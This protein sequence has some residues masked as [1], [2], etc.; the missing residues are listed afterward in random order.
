MMISKKLEVLYQKLLSEN[1]KKEIENI[2]LIIAIVSFIIHLAVIFLVDFGIINLN[3]QSDLFKN[4]I[5][6]IL[7]L[8]HI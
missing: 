3:I 4:P 5:A 6:A 2:I 8:I 1:T 7:S